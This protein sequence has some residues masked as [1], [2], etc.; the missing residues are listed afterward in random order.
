MLHVRNSKGPTQSGSEVENLP[1]LH[2]ALGSVTST[3]HARTKP[4]HTVSNLNGKPLLSVS[5]APCRWL[6]GNRCSG[7]LE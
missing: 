6:G 7:M 1:N 5:L 4:R 3:I 2:K